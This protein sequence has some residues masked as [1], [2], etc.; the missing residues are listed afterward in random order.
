[1]QWALVGQAEGGI[2]ASFLAAVQDFISFST[3]HW[4]FCLLHFL[5][6]AIW[7]AWFVVLGNLLNARGFSRSEIGRIYGTMPIGSMIAPLIMAVLADKY[8][9]TE[10]LIGVSH[11]IGAVLLFAMARARNAWPF[12]CCALLYAIVYSPTLNLVNSIVFAHDADIFGG[13]AQEGFPWIRVFGTIGWIA[14]GMSHTLILKKGEPVNERPLLL[15]CG[16]SVILGLFAFS[17]PETKPAGAEAESAAAVVEGEVAAVAVEAPAAA[18]QSII[19]GSMEMLSSNPIFFGVT[20]I[21]AMAMGLYFAFAALFVEK[22]GI[23]ARTVGPVMTLGQWIEIFFMLSLPWWINTVGMNWVLMIGISAWALRFGLFAIGKP[24][25][26]I[27]LGVAIHGICF[28]FFFAAGFINADEIAP[29]GLTATAQQLYGFLVYGL[30]MF[31]GSLGAG[32][33]NQRFTVLKSLDG[34]DVG[35]G[36]DAVTN[37]RMFWGIPFVIVLISA[38]LF[39]LFV[40]RG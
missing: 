10:V 1:M 16:L 5:E 7:G 13:K 17:L 25:A 20:F 33:L 36:T 2:M 9:N 21:A 32:W 14:A 24:F 8:F 28:D 30:G 26:L 15:A 37:W 3:T 18:S 34:E 35:E 38:V 12:F 29:E 4:R 31:L 23:P 27:L 11:L 19:G 40:M 39:W 6:F 22:S